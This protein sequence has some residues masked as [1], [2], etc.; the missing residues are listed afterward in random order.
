MKNVL[1]KYELNK[2]RSSESFLAGAYLETLNEMCNRL[3]VLKLLI[4]SGLKVPVT[5]KNTMM[6]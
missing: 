4:L 1:D 5:G 6:F 2:M 3:N